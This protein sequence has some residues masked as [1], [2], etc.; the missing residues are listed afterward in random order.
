MS[1]NIICLENVSKSFD[2]GKTTALKDINLQIRE[3]AFVAIMGPSGSGKSTLLNIIGTL[4]TPDSGNVVISG[5]D[6]SKLKDL[7]EFRRKTIGFVF[8]LH[9]LI[10]TLTSRENVEVPMYGTGLKPDEMKGRAL[11]LLKS[12]GLENMADKKPNILASGERQR[13][14]VARAL[15]NKPKIILADEPT[16]ALDTQNGEIIL[17]LLQNH[18]KTLKTTL[19]L[20]THEKC[21]K[22]SRLYHQYIRWTNRTL[23]KIKKIY[24]KLSRKD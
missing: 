8:Q 14:A 15:A 23:S 9:N 18:Q 19:I 2:N 3:G 1:N 7:N 6:I 22:T 21:C 11:E 5:V 12:V 10:P 17:D 16:G 24:R 4:D 13:V 20:V